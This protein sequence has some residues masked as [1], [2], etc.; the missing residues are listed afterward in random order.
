[1]IDL[2]I[3]GIPDDLYARYQ[4]LAQ[5]HQRSLSDETI[6][7]IEQAVNE[8][9]ILEQRREALDRIAERRRHLPPTPPD[10]PTSLEMLREDRDRD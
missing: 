7:L 8:E 5:Q 1:M 9:D 3:E 6:Y 10:A 4:R 2:L